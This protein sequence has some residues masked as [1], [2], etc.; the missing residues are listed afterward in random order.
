[1][2]TR[3]A[4]IDSKEKS[5]IKNRDLEIS[6]RQKEIIELY[7]DFPRVHKQTFLLLYYTA[8][9]I[10]ENSFN[11]IFLKYFNSE[12]FLELF[13]NEMNSFIKEINY[14]FSD[15]SSYFRYA[16]L[17]HLVM[18]DVLEIVIPGILKNTIMENKKES[19]D[20]FKRKIRILNDELLLGKCHSVYT[21]KKPQKYAQMTPEFYFI[22]N[23]IKDKYKPII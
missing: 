20:G 6:N 12:K 23:K 13:G 15:N 3:R 22:F 17:V 10:F 4:L 19:I 9:A 5:R 16:D 8:F 11:K 14:S 1:M 18:N 21:D 7:R 2:E